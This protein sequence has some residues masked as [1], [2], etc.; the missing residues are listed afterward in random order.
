MDLC[1]DTDGHEVN[2]VTMHA[3]VCILTE[4]LHKV[5]TLSQVMIRSGTNIV[6]KT[7]QK[8]LF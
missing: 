7:T 8:N 6:Q 4:T 1:S 5:K 3:A 2:F